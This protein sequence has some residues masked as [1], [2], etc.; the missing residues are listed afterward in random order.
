MEA[1]QSYFIRCDDFLD[2]SVPPA[3]VA[4]VEPVNRELCEA[5]EMAAMAGY[6]HSLH[7][8]ASLVSSAVPE[9]AYA[10]MH[11]SPPAVPSSYSELAHAFGGPL[12]CVLPGSSVPSRLA[13][14]RSRNSSGRDATWRQTSRQDKYTALANSNL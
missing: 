5:L 9:E 1:Y 12:H 3:M 2:W 13:T 4:P 11:S 14:A 10:T 8:Q 7:L 6:V